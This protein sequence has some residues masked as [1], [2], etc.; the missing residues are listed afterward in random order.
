MCLDSY[1]MLEFFTF[2]MTNNTTD[3]SAVLIELS[4]AQLEFVFPLCLCFLSETLLSSSRISGSNLRQVTLF[5][6]VDQELDFLVSIW[7]MTDSL[8][9]HGQWLSCTKSASRLINYDF[10]KL[11]SLMYEWATEQL[12]ANEFLSPQFTRSIK[13]VELNVLAIFRLRGGGVV[14]VLS[15]DENLDERFTEFFF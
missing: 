15:G 1:S 13:V 11:L 12:H 7:P 10:H 8:Y 9:L 6:W 3:S 5:K 4:M 2:F 14:A